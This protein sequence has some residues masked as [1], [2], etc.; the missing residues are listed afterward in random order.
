MSGKE[1][2]SFVGLA[3]RSLLRRIILLQLLWVVPL[4]VAVVGFFLFDSAP[5]LG[6]AVTFMIVFTLIWIIVWMSLFRA[7][8]IN[9]K[10]NR[11]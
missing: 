3:R 2:S 7:L 1:T 10:K 4:F 8:V 6:M 9:N 11:H 5:S